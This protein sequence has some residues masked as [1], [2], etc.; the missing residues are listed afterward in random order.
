M[1]EKA[2]QNGSFAQ[3]LY[4]HPEGS[5]KPRKPSGLTKIPGFS[6]PSWN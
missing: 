2:L 4:F 3:S 5:G 6:K 1:L